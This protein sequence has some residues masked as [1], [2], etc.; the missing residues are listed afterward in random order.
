MKMKLYLAVLLNVMMFSCN[1]EQVS[2]QAPYS[3]LT[4]KNAKEIGSGAG[5]G[6]TT[7]C[8]PVTS[9]TVKGDYRAG[10]TGL[11]S[12]DAAYAVKPCTNGQSVR[13]LAELIK[14]DTKAVLDAVDN[15]PLN[16]KYHYQ[17]T[18]MYGVYTVKMTVF[19]AVTGATLQTTSFSVSLVP[20]KV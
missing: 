13:V 19:E 20:K 15:M 16:G 7:A 8:L 14:F 2:P 9:F 11:S 12:I 10:E 17:S 4:S 5:G 6:G 3:H 18:G 1:Q